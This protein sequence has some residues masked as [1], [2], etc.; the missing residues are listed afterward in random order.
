VTTVDGVKDML[1]L[2]MNTYFILKESTLMSVGGQ[3]FEITTTFSDY[4]KTESGFMMPYSSNFSLPGL[5]VA[6]TSKKIEV[7][8][9]IDPVIFDMP[10]N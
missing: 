7:N 6:I 4:R 1:F 2:D 5:S 9:F 3:E 10:K 8:K